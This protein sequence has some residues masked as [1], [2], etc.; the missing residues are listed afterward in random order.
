MGHGLSCNVTLA[1]DSCL[2]VCLV[3]KVNDVIVGLHGRQQA[4]TG[5]KYCK[6][7]T[8]LLFLC[9][10]FTKSFRRAEGSDVAMETWFS[11]FKY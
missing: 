4:S 6:V 7:V 9:F 10:S 8:S 2:A 5:Q 3:N 1:G 11:C